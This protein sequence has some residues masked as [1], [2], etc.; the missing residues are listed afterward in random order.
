MVP[1]L[2]LGGLLNDPLGLALVAIAALLVI[3]LVGRLFL[4]VAWK[5]LVVAAVVVGAAYLLTVVGLL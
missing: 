5:I 4:R 3:I 2:Q 1:I